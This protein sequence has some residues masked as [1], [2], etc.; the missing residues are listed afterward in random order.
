MI[1]YNSHL[2]SLDQ[3][4]FAENIEDVCEQEADTTNKEEESGTIGT[5]VTEIIMSCRLLTITNSP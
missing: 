3:E 2:N 4:E 5:W 1:C